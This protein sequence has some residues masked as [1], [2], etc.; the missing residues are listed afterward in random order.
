MKN[1]INYSAGILACMLTISLTGCSDSSDSDV[2]TPSE[3]TEMAQLKEGDKLTR[4]LQLGAHEITIEDVLVNFGDEDAPALFSV[5]K[6]ISIDKEDLDGTVFTV[7]KPMIESFIEKWAK[8]KS[9]PFDT[10]EDKAMAAYDIYRYFYDTDID[11]YLFINLVNEGF[12]PN[13]LLGAIDDT[14]ANAAEAGANDVL[15]AIWQHRD[16]ISRSVDVSDTRGAIRDIKG[17]I[18]GVVD[19]YE[20]WKDFAE[21]TKPI[22][23]AVDG[24]CSFLNS[25]DLNAENYNL[26][27]KDIYEVKLTYDAGIWESDFFYKVGSYTGSHPGIAGAYLPKVYIQ[28]TYMHVVGPSFI[29]AGKYK[30]SP[31]VN[32]S[33]DPDSPIVQANGMV[34]V[35]Y[36]DCCC[37]R[38][39]SYL[40]F[41][42]DG[43]NGLEVLSFNR[44]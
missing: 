30:F 17:I 6:S 41:S 4:H 14:R 28:T 19:L 5:T 9:L 16:E 27:E 42:V 11:I 40:N 2:K 1:L 25:E 43:N 31:V 24:Y 34:Q 33:Q 38:Y 22:E 26:L 12:N 23:T 8:I 3:G 18:E 7:T 32:I 10:E 37:F 29:G 15:Y 44:K 39:V 35:T 21:H 13:T 36:G 20:V